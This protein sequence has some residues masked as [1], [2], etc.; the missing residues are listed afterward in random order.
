MTLVTFIMGLIGPIAAR[1]LAALSL[2]LVVLAGLD[3][4]MGTLK[5][6]VVNNLGAMPAATVQLAGLFGI[7]TCIGLIFGAMTFVVTW[8]TTAT[9]WTFAAK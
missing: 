7:G 2:S 6:M 4:A 3:I 9:F 8:K 1:V 5:T